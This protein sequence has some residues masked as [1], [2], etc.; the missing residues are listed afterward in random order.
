MTCL[1]FLRTKI[2]IIDL[3][4][5]SEELYNVVNDLL[6]ELEVVGLRVESL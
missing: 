5:N 4:I 3:H 2:S 1:L 6:D